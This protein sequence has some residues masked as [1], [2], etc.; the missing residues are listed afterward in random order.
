[1]AISASWVASSGVGVVA[2][3]P[4]AH[5]VDAVVVAAQQRV[6]GGAVA[7]L[8]GADQ[9]L[10][11]GLGSDAARLLTRLVSVRTPAPRRSRPARGR[12][13]RRGR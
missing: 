9:R 13:R 11:V 6:E 12:R 8:G 2:G 1:M 5:G 4:P 10:V 7:L 3:Q